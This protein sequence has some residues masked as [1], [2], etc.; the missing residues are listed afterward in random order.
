MEENLSYAIQESPP[1]A[2]TPLHGLDT[3]A[4]SIIGDV[5]TLEYDWDFGFRLNLGYRWGV[6]KW[7]LFAEYTYFHDKASESLRRD[8]DGS[9]YPYNYLK[10][11]FLEFFG[12]YINHITTNIHLNYNTLDIILQRPIYESESVLFRFL[13]GGRGAWIDQDWKIRYYYT[14]NPTIP[15]QTVKN[16][17]DFNGGGLRAGF[18]FEWLWWY[19]FGLHFQGTASAILGSYDNHY[20]NIEKDT[21]LTDSGNKYIAGNIHPKSTRIIPSYQC[22][23]GLQ[24]R[25]GWDKWAVNIFAD[26]EI[27]SWVDL[28][29]TYRYPLNHYD[30][31]KVGS[32]DRESVSLQ[33]LTA[34]IKVE[35]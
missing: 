17:W 32:W 16:K 3:A 14:A 28:N 9:V 18:N 4:V 29:Q 35:F 20:S 27:N 10:G 25:K 5:K 2:A 1:S 15:Y 22:L 26:W 13:F 31:A 30:E 34:G 24:W 7:D 19:G 21:S 12:S 33:G 6:S 8:P 11:L 23:I